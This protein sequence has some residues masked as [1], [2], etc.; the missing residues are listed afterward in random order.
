MTPEQVARLADDHGLRLVR[1]LWCGND[2]TIRAK[3]SGRHGLVGRLERGIGVTVGDA[4][5]ELARPAAAG[6]RAWA[7]WASTG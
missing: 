2:G 4:G 1:F 7:R 6:R 5:D 3:A